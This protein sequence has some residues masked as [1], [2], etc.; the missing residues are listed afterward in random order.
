MSAVVDFPVKP[1]ARPYLDAFRRPAGEPEWLLEERERGLARFAEL[2]FPS[3][4]GEA[5]RYL[6]LGALAERPMLPAPARPS[7]PERGVAAHGFAAA[8]WRLVLLDGR[9]ASE[10]SALE[11]LP[12][13]VWLGSINRAVRERPV[14]ARAALAAPYGSEPAAADPAR[15]F[16]ALN[17]ALFADGFVLEVAPGVVLDRPIEI[18]HLAS[19]GNAGSFHT[20]SLVALRTGARAD[21][22]ESFAGV[23][24]Y[25][26]NDV[27]AVRLDEGA[28]LVRTALVEEAAGAVHFGETAAYLAAESVLSDFVLVLDGGTVRRE[29]TIEAAGARTR[30]A[31]NGA[32]LVAGRR[33]A[34][35]VA[36]VDHRAPGGETREL[37]KGVAAGRGHGAFQGRITVRPG[38]QQVDAHQLSRNLLLGRRAVIDTKPELEIYA[39]DVKCA[40]GA[41]VGELDAM[42]LFYAESRGLD[43]AS[44]RALLLEGF[45]MGL[46]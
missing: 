18:L 19:G 13:G 16:S 5:W 33:Q 12:A 1:E 24:E 46:W 26:R 17:A 29:A 42:Q 22:V 43:P 41:T 23:G 34:N 4:R 28:E 45:V 7:V 2:G 40:H 38:A 25:W 20:R 9:F 27:L 32:Y 6:D 10:L 39:D 31:L 3:R 15:A 36:T 37:V 8:R 11:D 44:A 35:I 21:L 14:L 30:S